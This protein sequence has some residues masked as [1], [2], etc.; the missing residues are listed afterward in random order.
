MKEIIISPKIK[1]ERKIDFSFFSEINQFLL[2]V[3][4]IKKIKMMFDYKN[5]DLGELFNVSIRNSYYSTPIVRLKKTNKFFDNIGCNWNNNNLIIEGNC[6]SFLGA[7][8]KSGKINLLG[9]SSDYAGC[10]MS[11]GEIFIKGNSGNFLGSS[12]PGNKIGMNGGFINIKGYSGNYLGNFMRRGIILVESDVGNNCGENLIS[13]TILLGKKIGNN[14]G[15]GMKRGT[16]ILLESHK[17]SDTKF[18]NLGIQEINFFSLLRKF[19]SQKSSF[20]FTGSNIFNKYIGDKNI[21]GLGELLVTR[22]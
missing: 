6:G 15:L 13:G 12:Y 22:D 5:V 20:K 19:I 14:F 4:K 1:I 11:G 8:M 10:E 3:N 17:I 18:I 7:R 21:M 2:K 9:S 16:L